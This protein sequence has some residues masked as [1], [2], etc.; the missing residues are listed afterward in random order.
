MGA[1]SG[2][3]LTEQLRV[4]IP[5]CLMHAYN[6]LQIQTRKRSKWWSIGVYLLLLFMPNWQIYF[7]S[8]A[9]SSSL[10]YTPFEPENIYLSRLSDGLALFGGTRIMVNL[11]HIC[12]TSPSQYT[13]WDKFHGHRK[14]GYFIY[15]PC[16]CNSS[17]Q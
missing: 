6:L 14:G 16:M 7:D 1:H 10:L 17:V 12:M 15:T 8:V 13:S 11:A 2:S 4:L 9:P 5:D 3:V